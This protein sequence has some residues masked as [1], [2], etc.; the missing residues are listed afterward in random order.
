M[1]DLA[2]THLVTDRLVVRATRPDDAPLF[3]AYYERNRDHL[4]PWEPP[5][6]ATEAYWAG[7]LAAY[8]ADHATGAALHLLLLERGDTAA[9]LGTVNYTQIARGP[10]Q[11]CY[12]GFGLDA[13]AVGKGLMT[14]A[15]RRTLPF[16]FDEL[17][18]HRVMANH[19]PEN[20][21]SA[22]LLRRLGFVVEGYARDYLF[23][24]GAWRDH[25]LTSLT[26]PSGAPP[27]P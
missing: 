1:L 5:R 10:F 26:N 12:L 27:R 20:L 22:R 7:V 18:L 19:L 21:R 8:A 3:A 13:A 11:A 23:I 24:A 25:V 2:S 4:A 16:V 17:A 9:P 6:A 14:D 15:L